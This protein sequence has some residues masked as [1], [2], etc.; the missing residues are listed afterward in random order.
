MHRLARPLGILLAA[1]LICKRSTSAACL[2]PSVD[3][4]SLQGQLDCARGVKVV[5]VSTTGE[6]GRTVKKCAGVFRVKGVNH[7]LMMPVRKAG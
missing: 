3:L 1:L 4:E 5:S 2:Q 7:T 6:E